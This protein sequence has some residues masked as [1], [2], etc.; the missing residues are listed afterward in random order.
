MAK[1]TPGFLPEAALQTSALSLGPVLKVI[2]RPGLQCR[3]SN[4]KLCLYSLP[5]VCTPTCPH[6]LTLT[7]MHAQGPTRSH[8]QI[9]HT[10][11]QI[12][13]STAY[14]PLKINSL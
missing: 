12:L 5:L 4:I 13:H 1:S 7:H 8:T 2:G 9:A 3:L 14:G 11:F 10:W 6:V